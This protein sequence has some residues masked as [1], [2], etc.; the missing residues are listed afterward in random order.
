MN[1]SILLSLITTTLILSGGKADD[2]DRFINSEMKRQDV[3]GL[4][5]AVVKK[6]KLAKAK[7]YGFAN[8]E[9]RVPVTPETVFQSGSVGKQFTAAGVLLLAQEG[10]LKLDEPI[11]RFFTNA[12][13]A[14]SNISVR[15]LLNHTSGI[16]NYTSDTNSVNL[17][18]DYTEDELVRIATTMPLDFQPGS[19]W[20]YSNTGYVLLG[21]ITRTCSGQFYGDYLREKIFEPLG[22]NT[23][24]INETDLIPHR[25]A[26]YEFV[27]GV[28]KNQAWVSP[29]LNTTADGAL[30]LTVLDLAKWDAALHTDRPLSAEIRNTI[31]TPTQFG[32]GKSISIKTRGAGYACGW[33]IER[34][35]GRRVVHHSGSWQGF[36]S[37]IKRYLDD[38]VTVII[39][40]NSDSGNPIS[41]ANGVARRV[42]PT[43]RGHAIPDGNPQITK[44]LR[45]VLM[46]AQHDN[47]QINAFDFGSPSAEPP[48]W[49]TDIPKTVKALGPVESLALLDSSEQDGVL[50]VRYRIADKHQPLVVVALIN[51]SG[52]IGRLTI[53]P[54]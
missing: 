13:S 47:L 40:L 21:V 8:L 33:F 23:R 25:A 16:S 41:F 9:H 49:F 3:P 46:A 30:Y 7:G 31:W 26:G 28:L 37:N 38:G 14:W 6:G 19:N 22:M 5:L 2:I 1:N 36:K 34:E 18:Q 45:E 12:P 35:L 44:Q 52:R 50:N 32:G 20:S 24:I 11:T 43:L 54:E 17:R 53:E 39:L 15:H 4:A 42:L 48:N 10:R 51:Q 29:S 27:N